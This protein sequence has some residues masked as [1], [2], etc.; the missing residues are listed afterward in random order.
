MI[1]VQYFV[2]SV[3]KTLVLFPVLIPLY[4]L[5]WSIVDY[6]QILMAVSNLVYYRVFSLN[7]R[8]KCVFI[9]D[10]YQELQIRES[11]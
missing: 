6:L 4:H 10:S 9:L 8:D 7:L 11:I 3:G 5:C 2:L 1:R